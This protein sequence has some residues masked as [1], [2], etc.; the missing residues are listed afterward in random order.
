MN[1]ATA[2]ANAVATTEN[3]DKEERGLGE[4]RARVAWLRG[5]CGR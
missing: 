4:L 2:A 5:M 1:G 3:R